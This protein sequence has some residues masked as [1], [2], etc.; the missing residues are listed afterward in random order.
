[1]R[2]MCPVHSQT[3]VFTTLSDGNN[4]GLGKCLG[5]HG[6]N[7]RSNRIVIITIT[8]LSST[9]IVIACLNSLQDISTNNLVVIL[10]SK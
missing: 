2:G 6:T 8:P 9:H 3:L 7:F 4:R 5:L 1:M 10:K